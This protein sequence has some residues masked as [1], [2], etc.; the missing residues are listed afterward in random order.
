MYSK[1]NN[2]APLVSVIGFLRDKWNKYLCLAG[3]VSCYSKCDKYG[4][5]H[6]ELVITF[7]RFYYLGD[8][9]PDGSPGGGVGGMGGAVVL[10]VAEE[11]VREW[12]H[13]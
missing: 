2:D 8:L 11:G 5:K 1:K 10:D 9:L 13:Y 3:H 7:D 4:D 6:K 12:G